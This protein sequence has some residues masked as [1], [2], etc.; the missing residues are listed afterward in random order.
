MQAEKLHGGQPIWAPTTYAI[1]LWVAGDRDLARQFYKS[2]VRSNPR[3]WG[4]AAG[5]A[6]ATREWNANE[7][8]AVE[9]VYADWRGQLGASR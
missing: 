7:K 5:L 3:R 6:E 1:G 8:L 4:E 2:A 9:A